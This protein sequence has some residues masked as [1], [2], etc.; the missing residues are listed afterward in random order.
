M[1]IAITQK[2]KLSFHSIHLDLTKAFDSINRAT[3]IKI[4]EE[5]LPEDELRL[6]TWI[7]SNINL[8]VHH[9]NQ[10]TDYFSTNMGTPQGD[11]SSP[12]YFNLYLAKALYDIHTTFFT[13]LNQEYNNFLGFADDYQL[14]HHD[15]Q[16][17]NYIFEITKI[18]P[19]RYT[20]PKTNERKGD[21]DQE[22]SQDFF[23]DK[24]SFKGC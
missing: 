15:Q 20:K 5:I 18:I 3:L 14:I 24:Y 12:I 21:K 2:Y 19:K 6:N 11:T 4:F 13:K 1:M 9:K 22:N 16:K 10:S 8:K 17:L 23:K 7:I